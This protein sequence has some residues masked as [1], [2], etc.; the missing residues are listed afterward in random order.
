MNIVDILLLPFTLIYKGFVFVLLIPYYFVLGITKLFSNDKKTEKKVISEIKK[1]EEIKIVKG[2]RSAYDVPNKPMPETDPVKINELIKRKD[3]ILAEISEVKK[4][5]SDLASLSNTHDDKQHS[6][7][8]GIIDTKIDELI[9][10]LEPD[11]TAEP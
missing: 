7:L 3:E 2:T 9:C 4:A 6:E 8:I 11:N 1:G 10:Y 5:I